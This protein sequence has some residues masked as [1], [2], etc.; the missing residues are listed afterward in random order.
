M[1]LPLPLR[2]GLCL[3]VRVRVRMRVRVRV[4]MRVR[5][6]VRV[7]VCVCVRAFAGAVCC[8]VLQSHIEHSKSFVC[9]HEK[10]VLL[11]F[12]PKLKLMD[13]KKVAFKKQTDIATMFCDAFCVNSI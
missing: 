7:C 1:C 11:D 3:C 13:T 10:L 4:R 9:M 2:L 8:V 6:R 12:K 5:V